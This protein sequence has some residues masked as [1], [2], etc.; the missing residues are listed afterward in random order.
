MSLNRQ[1]LKETLAR[2]AP[3]PATT[4]S[5]P[6]LPGATPITAQS[7][8]GTES[9]PAASGNSGAGLTLGAASTVTITSSDGIFTWQVT[10]RA[11]TLA[12]GSTV[13]IPTL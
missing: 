2:L 11:A 6:A 1:Q 13:N 12:D 7:G 9:T 10:T 8:T 4:G 5:L 3:A